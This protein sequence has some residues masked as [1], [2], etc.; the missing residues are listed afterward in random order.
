MLKW[1]FSVDK[2]LNQPYPQRKSVLSMFFVALAYGL[3][4]SFFLIGFKP[5]DLHFLP[6]PRLVTIGIKYGLI[7]LFVVLINA[8]IK[9]S[10]ATKFVNWNI[11]MELFTSFLT[12]FQ[13]GFFNA[14]F[15][16]M[17]M[18]ALSFSD[19]FW[20]L[21][22]NT[23]KLGVLPISL[24]ILYLRNRYLSKYLKALETRNDSSKSFII[25]RDLKGDAAKVALNKIIL[26]KSD[27]HYLKVFTENSF[28]YIRETVQ[29]FHEKIG[30][31]I[32]KRVHRS[33]IVN[34]NHI[35]GLIKRTRKGYS[36]KMSNGQKV[37]ISASYR[38]S[39]KDYLE[40]S[41]TS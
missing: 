21:Q 18:P 4:V 38:S 36:L 14:L 22:W 37:N 40:L 41:A 20:Q 7:T 19:I 24:E 30:D 16:S 29:K 28:F 10:I 27:G 6:Y 15:A 34:T 11:K 35:E 26:V 12:L 13:V 23:M 8:L 3:F 2:I 33:S 32:F 25:L 39:I 9:R 31:T 1:R 17:D 5:F